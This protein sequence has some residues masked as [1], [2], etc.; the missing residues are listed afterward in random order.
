MIPLSKAVMCMSTRDRTNQELEWYEEPFYLCTVGAY[1]AERI[2][3]ECRRRKIKYEV[4]YVKERS[5]DKSKV[6]TKARTNYICPH[7]LFGFDVVKIEVRTW[8]TTA[9]QRKQ[10][11]DWAVTLFNHREPKIPNDPISY[12][13]WI[14]PLREVR[15]YETEHWE[16]IEQGYVTHWV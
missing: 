4:L 1:A 12:G 2:E 9:L 7:R 11:A 10:L 8:K 14:Q 13:V 6:L 3:E 16:D 5:K 15:D